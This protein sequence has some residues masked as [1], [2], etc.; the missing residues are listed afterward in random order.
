MHISQSF[1]CK[2]AAFSMWTCFT[3]LAA[4]T[5]ISPGL[6]TRPYSLSRHLPVLSSQVPIHGSCISFS[7]YLPEL[8]HSLPGFQSLPICWCI[9]DLHLVPISPPASD[10]GIIFLKEHLHW[11]ALKPSI[12]SPFKPSSISTLFIWQSHYPLI[13][14]R[15][16]KA[17][18]YSLSALYLIFCVVLDPSLLSIPT[19]R[20]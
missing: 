18:L 17:P 19:T 11:V 10:S 4:M 12:L 9:F 6:L 13:Q 1:Y 7:P 5:V 16:A 20:T 15:R 2:T 8:A 14:V 3:R